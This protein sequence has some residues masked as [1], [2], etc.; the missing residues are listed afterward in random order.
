MNSKRRLVKDDQQRPKCSKCGWTFQF[1]KMKPAVHLSETPEE[2]VKRQFNAHVCED[3][4]Q[5]AARIVRE[6]TDKT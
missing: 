4:S 2:T 3:F 6:A 5:A 1:G